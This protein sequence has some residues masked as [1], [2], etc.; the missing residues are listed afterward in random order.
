[1]GK[2]NGPRYCPSLDKKIERFPDRT[3]HQIWLE[4]EGLTGDVIYPNGLNVHLPE[5]LQ[6]KVGHTPLHHTL[7]QHTL[8]Q[9]TLLQHTL[10]QHTLFHSTPFHSTPPSTAHP[11]TAHPFTAPLPPPPLPTHLPSPPSSPLS[12]SSPPPPPLAPPPLFPH[13]PTRSY[14]QSAGSRLPRSCALAMLWSTTSWTQ[15]Y[16]TALILHSYCTHTALIL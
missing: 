16:C 3:K 13:P 6:L 7:L 4:P 5:E 11:S 12:P 10:P 2:G 14:A 1:M 8:P 15:R 9:H